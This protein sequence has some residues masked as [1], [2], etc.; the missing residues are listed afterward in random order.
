[1]LDLRE[2]TCSLL[3]G[4][5]EKNARATLDKISPCRFCAESQSG[6][7]PQDANI[8]PHLA[9]R[10]PTGNLRVLFLTLEFRHGTFSGNGVLAQSQA[11]GLAKA[12]HAVLVVSGCP[13]DLDVT[14]DSQREIS[15]RRPRRRG[16]GG[17]NA[18]VPASKWGKLNARCPWRSWR[19]PRTRTSPPRADPKLRPRR[20]PRD[21]LASVTQTW[22]A[23]ETTRQARLGRARETDRTE[24]ESGHRVLLSSYLP[25]VY[26][27][28]R[29]FAATATR[30]TRRWN[31]TRR[32]PPPSSRCARSTPTLREELCCPRERRWRPGWSSRPRGGRPAL[33]TTHARTPMTTTAE[34]GGVGTT[35][36]FI[37]YRGS[38]RGGSVAVPGQDARFP[39]HVLRPPVP[40]EG[41]R[42]GS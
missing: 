4:S 27:N 41:T 25:F 23:A 3:A 15:T 36:G 29:V 11:H 34:W 1:M 26:S 5:R 39:A 18:P 7:F 19:T 16:G 38:R 33:A 28:Y 12:G 24:S 22:R 42:N 10:E 17:S 37:A 8:A 31:E 32:K 9:M 13:D 20:R 21:R 40:R 2:E 30:R 14:N 35:T 6:I